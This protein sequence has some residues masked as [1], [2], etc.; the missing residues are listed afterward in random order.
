MADRSKAAIPWWAWG[1][2]VACAIIP[3][4]TLGGAIPGAIGVGG[5]AA[6]IAAARD[7]ARSTVT[8]LIVCCGITAVCWGLFLAL[9]GGVALL[10]R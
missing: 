3:I 10:S 9:L 2:A 5:A 7:S 4:L 8:R 6:C 1:F